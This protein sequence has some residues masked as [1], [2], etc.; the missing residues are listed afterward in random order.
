MYMK[1]TAGLAH[2]D[3]SLENVMFS[4]EQQDHVKLIDL[5]MC[6]RV[7]S[8]GGGPQ[9]THLTPQSCRGKPSYVAPEVVR[10]EACDPFASD[11]WSLG[12][13]LY[14]MLMG[15]PLYNSP[16]DLAFSVMANGGIKDIVE[17]YEAYGLRPSETA[18][19]LV[20]LMCQSDPSHRITLEEV[21]LHPF[22]N[23]TTAT[24][25]TTENMLPPI[26]PPLL[27]L[28]LSEGVARG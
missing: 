21:L 6:L 17:A 4:D 28:C 20:Y 22:L 24:T 2:H 15:R 18:K 14:A 5:G 1:Q 23:T 25:A 26:I 3:V 13:C 11:V 8:S 10:E 27:P 12:V 19:D 7:P 16:E 9:P